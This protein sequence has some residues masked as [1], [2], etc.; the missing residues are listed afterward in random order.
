M[1]CTLEDIAP[2]QRLLNTQERGNT[3]ARN[4]LEAVKRLKRKDSQ[5]LKSVSGEATANN[6]LLTDNLRSRHPKR[7]HSNT[8]MDVK[9]DQ[10]EFRE[11]SEE[12]RKKLKLINEKLE[13][14]TELYEGSKARLTIA[15][16]TIEKERNCIPAKIKDCEAK[17]ENTWSNR[18]S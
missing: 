13:T 7:K 2:C 6:T 15:E 1:P 17:H 12:C 14:N 11:P 16:Q 18:T 4:A 8:I 10:D 5:R 3:P 9:S